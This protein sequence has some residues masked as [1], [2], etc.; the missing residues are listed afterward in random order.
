MFLLYHD[1][2]FPSCTSFFFFFISLN[3]RNA[4]VNTINQYV[5]GSKLLYEVIVFHFR[6]IVTLLVISHVDI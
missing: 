5:Q 3:V 2:S 1:I 4:K 6:I